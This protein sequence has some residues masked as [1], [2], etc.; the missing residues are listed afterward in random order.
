MADKKKNPRFVT[1]LGIAS[2]P[3]VVT[4][5]TKYVKTG[6]WSTKITFAPTDPGV[7]EFLKYLDDQVAAA[8]A[9]MKKENPKHAKA[10]TPVQAYRNE[11]DK[12]G[13]ETGRIEFMAK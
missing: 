3:R 2:W 13:N 11:T 6:E 8:V 5:D 9:L 1:P 4:P 10:I 7:P 12:E